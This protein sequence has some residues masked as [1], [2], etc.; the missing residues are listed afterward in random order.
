ML[1]MGIASA[2]AFAQ[3][4]SEVTIIG[5]L[6]LTGPYADSGA[7]IK[8]GQEMALQQ[9]N[10][11]ILGKKIN[12]VALDSAGDVGT[13]VRRVTDAISKYHPTAIVG[14]WADNVGAAI[15]DL[16]GKNKV[17]Y[18]WSGGPVKCDRYVFQWAPS[19]Y[20][21]VLGVTDYL[22][23]QYPNATKWYTLTADYAFGD[24]LLNDE[25]QIIKNKGIQI[26]GGAKAVLGETNFSRYMT[27]VA[28]SNANVL[29][30]NNFGQDTANALRAA[31]SFGLNKKMHIIVPWS[32]GFQMYNQLKP[33]I[34]EGVIAGTAFYYSTNTPDAKSFADKYISKYGVPPGYPAGSGYSVMRTVL[35]G[36][37]KA[38]SAKPADLVK[39]LEGWH[40]KG[41][42]GDMY[43][44]PTDN[45]TMRPVF[46]TQGNAASAMNGKFDVAK[47]VDTLTKANPQAPACQMGGF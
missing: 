42:V 14:G 6:P 16:A 30:L 38:G 21:G 11:Q 28:S 7:L 26:V 31:A 20:S 36:I 47:V 9:F 32:S 43:I 13:A 27:A 40:F 46:I 2:V 19:Y 35:R 37:Q 17:A 45:L 22:L 15:A 25:H 5:V 23:K 1:V 29:V 24:T 4:S 18:Y 39:A 44:D 33:A 10:G 34:T 8:R 41:V 12:F 3:N